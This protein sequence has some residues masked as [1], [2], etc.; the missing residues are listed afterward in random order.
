MLMQDLRHALRF[1]RK[2]PIVTAAA[3][4]TLALGVG[5]TTA[6]FSVVHAVILRPLPY[7]DP[8]RLIELFESNR[9]GGTWRVS[10]PNYLSWTER[11]RSFDALA[12]FNG[13]TVILTDRGDPER[14]ISSAITASMFRVLGLPPIVGTPFGPDDERPGSARVALLAE[15]L[16][17][18]RFGGDPSI[19]GQFITLNGEGHQVIGVV[20][21]AFR[22]VG[23]ARISSAGDPQI[24][25]PL[26]I[27]PARENRGNHVLRVVGRLR[28]GV[29][30]EQAGNEMRAIA[31]ALE[32]EFPASNQGW[33]VRLDPIADSMFAPQVRPSLFVSLAAVATV[34]LIACA[35]VANLFLA[36][37]LS[38]KRELAIRA[39]LGASP[40]RVVRQ[41]LTESLCLA[42]IGGVCGLTAAVLAVQALRTWLPPTLPRVDEIRVDGTVL[43]FGLLLS[44]ASGVLFGLIPAVRA[45]RVNLSPA[46]VESGK[47]LL[48][49]T[50]ARLREGRRRHARLGR[51]GARRRAGSPTA[52]LGLLR[53]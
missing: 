6:I 33:S 26:A 10:A 18:S 24:F 16:W 29:T 22:D 8:D 9:A 19:V 42:G 11:T 40:A 49:S 30:L 25:L 20:P 35:N 17:R 48:G 50:R 21:R 14:L 28:A 46:L 37:G 5:G 2:A 51:R 41:L 4:L 23:R 15:P 53:C 52:R 36:R 3:V 1:L 43:G 47:G 13:G 34:F 39:A 45:A 12:A 38:R 7:P 27:D 31:A 32:Q 44:M